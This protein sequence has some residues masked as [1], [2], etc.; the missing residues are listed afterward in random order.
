[1]TKVFITEALPDLFGHQCS[2]PAAFAP[3]AWMLFALVCKAHVL[4]NSWKSFQCQGSWT[5]YFNRQGKKSAFFFF[6]SEKNYWGRI[7]GNW[8]G[9]Q[10]LE[11]IKVL[12]LKEDQRNNSKCFKSCP[13]CSAWYHKTKRSIFW[14]LSWLS[15]PGPQNQN[16]SSHILLLKTWPFLFKWI[17]GSEIE[18]CKKVW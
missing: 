12:L 13:S 1:M 9:R 5:F 10:F 2:G 7:E 4:F 8:E 17:K 15:F 16:S 3:H 14:K 18:E 11:M 6:L